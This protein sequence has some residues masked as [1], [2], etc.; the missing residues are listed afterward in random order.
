MR[1]AVRIRGQSGI[2]SQPLTTTWTLIF[3]LCT[4]SFYYV[5]VSLLFSCIFPHLPPHKPQ[6]SRFSSHILSISPLFL[7]LSQQL[8]LPLL[9]KSALMPLLRRHQSISKIPKYCYLQI[10]QSQASTQAHVSHVWILNWTAKQVMQYTAATRSNT[11]IGSSC[12]WRRRHMK[13]TLRHA[14]RISAFWL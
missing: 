6:I 11:Y 10:S 5:T 13:L 1:K 12:S 14:L 3:G 2:F 8:E 4:C 7:S 9:P